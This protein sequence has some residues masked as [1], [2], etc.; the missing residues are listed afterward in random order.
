LSSSAS[1]TTPTLQR[2]LNTTSP[3][4]EQTIAKMQRT[5]ARKSW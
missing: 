1:F 5:R 4:R 3:F 2:Q